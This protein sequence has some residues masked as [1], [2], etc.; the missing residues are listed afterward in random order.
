MILKDKNVDVNKPD[1]SGYTLLK[2]CIFNLSFFKFYQLI[3]AGADIDVRGESSRTCLILLCSTMKESPYSLQVEMIKLLLQ[4]GCN[5]SLRDRHGK[6]ALD[7]IKEKNINGVFNEVEKL[8]E[9]YMNEEKDRE[10]ISTV[11]E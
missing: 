11:C 5:A 7:Y 1:N 8:L 4:K 10:V 6:C 2:L 9:S 3:E